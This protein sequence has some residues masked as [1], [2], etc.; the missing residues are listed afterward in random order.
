MAMLKSSIAESST[1]AASITAAPIPPA[2]WAAFGPFRLLPLQRV[3]LEDGRPVKLGSRAFDILAALAER[4]GAIVPKHELIARVWPGTVVEESNL[5]VHVAA[6]RRALRDSAGRRMIGSVAGQG[7]ALLP[8]VQWQ[9]PAAPP[10]PDD[11]GA[12]AK[13]VQALAQH[14]PQRRLVTLTG[15]GG[16]GKSTAAQA[17]A[18]RLGA[19]YC[20]H[21]A[22][23]A[24]AS[25][26]AAALGDA[27][28]L[29]P[30]TDPVPPLRAVV[31]DRPVLVVLDN[32]ER[33]IDAAATLAERLLR[34][35]PDVVVL[36]TS[37]EALRATGEWVERLEPLACPPAGPLD[38]AAALAFPAVALFMQRTAAVHGYALADDD[39]QAVAELCRRLDGLPL[40]LELAGER[41]DL[42]QPRELAARLDARLQ[43]LK[44]GRRTAPPRHRSL[45]ATL[46]WSWDTLT[47]TER[48][49]LCRL[50]LCAG[51]FTLERATRIAAQE[52]IGAAQ[53]EDAVA[54][55]VA[56]SLLATVRHSGPPHCRLYE[57]VRVH[58]LAQLAPGDGAHARFAADCIDTVAGDDPHRL[59]D[60][61]TALA[62]AFGP[63]GDNAVGTALLVASATAWWDA[64]RLPEHR[65]WL[66]SALL[67]VTGAEGTAGGDAAAEMALCG[68]LGAVRVY[69]DGPGAGRS[70][71]ARAFALA[72]QLNDVE[73]LADAFSG[74]AL[75]D[76][77]AGDYP[78]ALALVDR[79]RQAIRNRGSRAAQLV[80]DRVAALALHLAGEQGAAATLA[81]ALQDQT[82]PA[83]CTR[84][85]TVLHTDENVVAGAVLA[86]T[87][88]LL[89]YPDDALRRAQGALQR[90]RAVGADTSLCYVLGFAL[91]PVAWWRGDRA[92]A[93]A[94][95][96]ELE[97]AARRLPKW[98]GLAHQYRVCVVD[99]GQTTLGAA[100]AVG[101]HRE[102]LA[103][104]DARYL[105]DALLRRALQGDARWC[106]AELRRL[107]G[108]RLLAGAD[109]AV[110][111]EAE[112][113]FRDA[114]LLARNQ[115]ARAWELRAAISLARMWQ[116]RGAY[117]EARALLETASAGWT[118]GQTSADLVTAGKLL[119]QWAPAAGR[120][121]AERELA[122]RE[123]AGCNKAGGAQGTP[124]AWRNGS[125]PG[126]TA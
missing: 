58:A 75:E 95:L 23:V 31:R 96:A 51:P 64:G 43:L 113:L 49:V 105:D 124:P 87:R 19:H 15:P 69:L 112:R 12:H 67:R 34:D 55:L 91:F 29:P 33:A 115:G 66:E 89:G 103:T 86:R 3:L 17:V 2:C 60:V 59:D 85:R 53:V 114:L 18:A 108:E 11:A 93:L 72:E 101:P 74:L 118:E 92:V 38:A 63:A 125:C 122:E 28:G 6:L 47:A 16:V 71:F 39:A 100:L 90:A 121:L 98:R 45:R 83:V 80:H 61:R 109:H 7:Y 84:R 54:A 36:A 88:W 116:Q 78:A 97:Q 77:L 26:P 32:C 68:A 48:T 21:S 62:W 1:T 8:P 102:T 119:A 123:P 5:R 44:G 27:L 57:N 56:K 126:V 79:Y 4:H 10:L 22:D 99:G 106:A 65:E 81:R 14:L 110:R 50:A 42:F 46:E 40:A 104:L 20:V 37:R 25:D 76:M 30:G 35:V 111:L 94:A 120:E 24:A 13:L 52:D 107:H 82:V 41:L 70:A 117:I 73:R 9:A